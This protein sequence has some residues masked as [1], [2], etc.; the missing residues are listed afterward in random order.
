MNRECKNIVTG[1]SRS[2]FP[3]GFKERTDL[4][5]YFWTEETVNRLL[6]ALTPIIND[7]DENVENCYHSTIKIIECETLV[8]DVRSYQALPF[9]IHRYLKS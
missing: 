7:S 3:D 8:N 5:Q 2:M 4:E 6:I 9:L 1:K